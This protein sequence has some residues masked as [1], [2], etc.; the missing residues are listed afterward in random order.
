MSIKN[1]QSTDKQGSG[2]GIIVRLFWFFFGNAIL[3]ISITLIFRH[4]G[5]LFHTADVVFWITVVA[6]VLAR[7]LDIRF[8]GGLTATGLPASMAHWIKYV[9]LLLICSTALWVISHALNYLIVNR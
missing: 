3:F 9:T 7:Y 2:L 5:G 6:L 1:D 8:Y 4:R